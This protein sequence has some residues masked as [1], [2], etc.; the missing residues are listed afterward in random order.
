VARVAWAWSGAAANADGAYAF[1]DGL[2]DAGWVLGEN[3]LIEERHY[4]EPNQMP[5]LVAELLAWKPDVLAGTQVPS[6][7]FQQAT[8]SIPIVFA[9]V[10][11]PVGLGLVASYGRPGGNITGTSRTAGSTLTRKLLD[12]LGQLV[13]GL[14]RLAVVFDQ[15]I[16]SSL[17]DLREIEAVARLAGM[18]V[19]T[20]GLSAGVDPR[21]PLLAA[22]AGQPQAMLAAAGGINAVIQPAV[23]AFATQHQLPTATTQSF[24]SGALLYYGPNTRAL[25]WR[26]GNYHVDRILRGAKAGDLP[27]EAPTTFDVIVNRTTAQTVGLQIPPEFAAQITEWVD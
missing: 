24:T 15:S 25:V 18:A 3:L 5:R 13:P 11:D 27:V 16:P 1:H 8:T 20:V 6:V 10:A 21:P 26:A 19:Q 9:G 17:S 4:G 7:A 22:L 23:F 14:A 2:R 12:L